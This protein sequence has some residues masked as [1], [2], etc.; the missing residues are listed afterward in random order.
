MEGLLYNGENQLCARSSAIFALMTAVD[1]KKFP[2]FSE[3]MIQGFDAF[4]GV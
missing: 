1:A 2:F 4:I 3:E